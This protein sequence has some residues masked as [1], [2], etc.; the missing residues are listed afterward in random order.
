MLQI[1]I[2]CIV[3]YLPNS[4]FSK[5]IIS[6]TDAQHIQIK[7][8]AWFGNLSHQS[9]MDFSV[10]KV[11]KFWT[12]SEHVVILSYNL[13]I[14]TGNIFLVPWRQIDTWV[15]LPHVAIYLNKIFLWIWKIKNYCQHLF[16]FLLIK[17]WM[18]IICKFCK[19]NFAYCICKG[20]D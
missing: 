19:E 2:I 11:Y 13:T 6:S 7:F 15:L 5:W 14:L 4:Q 10:R 12:K 3:S 1:L 16:R 20:L 8:S 18:R 17:A 9:V